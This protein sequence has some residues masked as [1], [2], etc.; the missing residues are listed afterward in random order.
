MDRMASNEADQVR[1]HSLLAE[2]PS[3]EYLRQDLELDWLKTSLAIC[4]PGERSMILRARDHKS[5]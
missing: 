2:R 1:R 3:I 5:N 4:K